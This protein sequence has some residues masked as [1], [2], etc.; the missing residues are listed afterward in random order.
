MLQLI[1]EIFLAILLVFALYILQRLLF[2]KAWHDVRRD[3]EDRK[4]KK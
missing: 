4:N 2:N 1:I 3:R